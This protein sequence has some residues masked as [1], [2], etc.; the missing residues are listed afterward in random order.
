MSTT[1]AGAFTR[2][3][4]GHVLIASLCVACA[5]PAPPGT[6]D[7]SG[8]TATAADTDLQGYQLRAVE[9][10][11]QTIPDGPEREYFRGMLAVRSGRF[12]DAVA[13]LGRALPHLRRSNPKRAAMALE[14]MGT[15]Y[16]AENQ[17]GDAA[18]AY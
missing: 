14:A 4:Y 7:A 9:T 13:L 12:G 5:T 1:P 3:S 11:I 17:Y 15:A 8:T 18:R 10:H 6:E 2:F 16:R